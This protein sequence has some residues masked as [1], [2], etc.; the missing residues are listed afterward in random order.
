MQNGGVTLRPRPADVVA[1]VAATVLATG[2]LTGCSP[3]ADAPAA[4]PPSETHTSEQTPQPSASMD[5]SAGQYL[6][7]PEGVELTEPGTEL[8][9]GDAAVVAWQPTQKAVGAVEVT[10][11][12]LE[13]TSF[14]R[15]FSGWQLEGPVPEAAPY[16]VHVTVENVGETDLGGAAIPLYVVDGNDALVEYSTFEG[17]FK[18]CDSKG[19]PATFGPGRTVRRCLVYLAPSGGRLTAV[20][21]RPTQEFVPITWTGPV[22]D[23]RRADPA[24]KGRKGTKRRQ[25]R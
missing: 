6:P 15:S 5:P 24:A 25:R 2:L 19:F 21:F 3:E 13:L 17:T 9:V 20:S 14:K 12:R 7:V 16:F 22:H 11:R 18:P 10:V 1:A 23:L 4:A 8:S